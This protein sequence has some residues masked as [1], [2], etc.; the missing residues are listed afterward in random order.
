MEDQTKI[1]FKWQK[2]EIELQYS[3]DNDT[4]LEENVLYSMLLSF[5]NMNVKSKSSTTPFLKK[6]N[7]KNK[8]GCASSILTQKDVEDSRVLIQNNNNTTMVEFTLPNKGI[9]TE[10][11]FRN[12]VKICCENIRLREYNLL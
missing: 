3:N 10:M 5:S 6:W 8:I 11:W 1:V 7:L 9:I 2:M 4:W 12:T